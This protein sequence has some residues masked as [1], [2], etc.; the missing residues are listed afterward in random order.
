MHAVVELCVQTFLRTKPYGLSMHN[1]VGTC[2]EI[3]PSAFLSGGGENSH[4]EWTG[5]LVGYFESNP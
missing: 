4:M 5:M 3:L 2:A 1:E